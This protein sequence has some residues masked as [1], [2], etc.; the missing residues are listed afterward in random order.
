MKNALVRNT[1][2]LTV[3][4]LAMRV[5]G[6]LWQVWLAG[7]IGAA[8]VGLF[9]L[10]MSVG[11]LF[12]TVAI[13]GVRFAV[14]RL[15]SE[16]L[17]LGREGSVDAVVARAGLYAT[18]FG[19][20]AMGALY[21]GSKW[22]AEKWIGDMRTVPSLKLLALALPAGGISGLLAGYFTA[23]GRVWKSAA[24][25]LA[26]QFL[27]MGLIA[28][29]IRWAEG[30]GLP[31]VC[32][33]IV[34][35]G[36]A[37]DVAGALAML[38]LYLLDR[39]RFAAQGERGERLTGRMLRIAAP[40][41]LSAYARSA[42][43][44]F[45]Q[46]L[47]PRGLRLSG[48]SADGALAGYGVINGMALPLLTFP[49]CLPAALAEMLVPALTASQMRGETEALRRTVERML[50]AAVWFS[51]PVGL[52][53]LVSADA[54]G[55]LVYHDPESAR[56]IRLLAPMAPLIYTDIVT[57]GCLKGLGEMTRSMAYN[58]AEAALGLALV[59][60]L[61]PRWALAGYV[62]TLYA[63]EIFNFTLSI[64]RLR[65]VTHCRILPERDEKTVAKR[66]RSA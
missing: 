38:A 60:A 21:F 43:T 29:A 15:V 19:F 41:A 62:F 47:V 25:Q 50:R 10:V 24:E 37:A 2:V 5:T 51:L 22:V 34:G 40:L 9:Q 12:S 64:L 54:L 45:R 13:S 23:V 6:M 61:L 46:L 16:E 18:L 27:R 65:A 36:A 44:T 58:V 11:F 3:S 56:F 14:T 42:L 57:D 4:A 31:A 63:C 20:L 48:F 33:A 39:R 7:R 59:W 55:E 49:A 53:F 35:A 66:P 1:A 32:A 28:A 52:F 17:G 26:E 8:G 30:R